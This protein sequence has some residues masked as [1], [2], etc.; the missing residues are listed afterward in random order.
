MTHSGIRLRSFRCRFEF[1]VEHCQLRDEE[2]D[3]RRKEIARDVV[4]MGA[5]SAAMTWGRETRLPSP[6][7]QMRDHTIDLGC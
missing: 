4:D 7:Y 3:I 2:L 6:R 1:H 5:S